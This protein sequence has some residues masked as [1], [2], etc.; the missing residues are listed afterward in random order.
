MRLQLTIDS[1]EYDGGTGLR[2][3]P[4]ED[5]NIGWR[6]PQRFAVHEPTGVVVGRHA[7]LRIEASFQI[8]LHAEHDT[9]QEVRYRPWVQQLTGDK[10]SALPAYAHSPDAPAPPLKRSPGRRIA[11]RNGTTDA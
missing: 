11:E 3:Q 9:A 5:R 1:S 6:D 2:W 10:R 7:S 8:L 4:T